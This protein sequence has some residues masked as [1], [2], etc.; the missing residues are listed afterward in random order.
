MNQ[1]SRSAQSPSSKVT[2]IRRRLLLTL[3]SEA[4]FVLPFAASAQP[5][6]QRPLIAWLSS[7]TEWNASR[8]IG[9]LREGLRRLGDEQGQNFDFVSR[10]ADSHVDRLAPLA[11]EVVRLEPAVIVAGAVDAA[12]AVRN[13]TSS[14]PI[15]SGALADAIHL[16]LVK[17]YAHPGGNVT[18]ITPYVEGLPAKQLELAREVVPGASK[19]GLLG[20]T[21]DPKALPQREELEEAAR[22]LGIS[23]L[24]P[25]VSMPEDLEGAVQE[26]GSE[27]VDVVVV[28]QT[29]M[30]LGQRQKIAALMTAQRLPAVYGYREHIDEGGL[31][32]YGV[33]LQWCWLRTASYVHKILLGA[34]PADLPLEFPPGLQMVINLKTAKA[35]GV[36]LSPALIARADEIIE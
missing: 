21:N 22:K 19:I 25:D 14:I 35:I 20:N 13:A 8:Y 5:S 2:S 15:V 11:M 18:G 27:R 24:A 23:V 33:D 26:L 30:L 6:R 12:V 28:L 34:A 32:S 17:N 9:F 4:G 29:T 7:A 16:G 3:L 36:S 10:F 1:H 31:V